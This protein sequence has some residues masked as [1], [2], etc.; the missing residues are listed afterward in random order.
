VTALTK[1]IGNKHTTPPPAK[2]ESQ[3]AKPT[4][5]PTPTASEPVK[6]RNTSVKGEGADN[7]DRPKDESP[8]ANRIT[9]TA[10]PSGINAPAV[11]EPLPTPSR[12]EPQPSDTE[13]PMLHPAGNSVTSKDHGLDPPDEKIRPVPREQERTNAP[14]AS[15]AGSGDRL[16]RDGWVPIKHSASAAVHDV[17]R[18]AEGRDDEASASGRL[19][20]ANGSQGPDDTRQSFDLETPR[21]RTLDPSDEALIAKASHGDG[22]LDTVLHKVEGKENFWDISRMYYNSGRYYRALWKANED[23]VPQIDKLYRNTVIRIP[24]PED[25]DQAYIDP[26]ASTARRAV[27]SEPARQRADGAES[28]EAR[29]DLERTASQRTASGEGVPVR[30]SSRADADLNLPVS[31]ISTEDASGKGQSSRGIRQAI[32]DDEEA[33]IRPRDAVT[34]PIYK[35]RQYDTLRTIA[36]DTLGDA[37][38]ANEILELNQDI[39]DD[40]KHLIVGQVLELPEDARTARSRSRK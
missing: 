4:P 27:A 1:E 23:K 11:P 35:V 7:H 8:K 40:P 16:A 17:Q 36:R 31:D 21:K 24:P 38:R 28:D 29:T 2:D 34:R 5:G 13:L 9:A 14:A 3:P 25:L 15:I 18:E 20:S 22:K 37:R 12:A 19:T 33:E 10:E 39:I 30:R 6:G 32:R 26:P